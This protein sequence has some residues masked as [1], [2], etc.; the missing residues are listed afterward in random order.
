MKVEDSELLMS[1]MSAPSQFLF[2]LEVELEVECGLVRVLV[3]NGHQR[4]DLGALHGSRELSLCPARIILLQVLVLS[5][6]RTG[7]LS[8]K[9]IVLQ[10]KDM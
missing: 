8:W 2:M 5:F 7:L 4:H 6:S 10:Q 3:R 1:S 9:R